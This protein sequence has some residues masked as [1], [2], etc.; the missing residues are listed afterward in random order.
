[1]IIEM[2]EGADFSFDDYL[3]FFDDYPPN[4][5]DYRVAGGL[6]FFL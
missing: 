1:M 3:E 2:L 6:H 5:D 4:F